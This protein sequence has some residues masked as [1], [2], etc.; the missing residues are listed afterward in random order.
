MRYF[1]STLVRLA[2]FDMSSPMFMYFYFNSTL[3]RLALLSG[4]RAIGRSVF[5]FYISTIS[6]NGAA[7]AVDAGL[8][9]QFYISTISTL[10]GDIDALAHDISI[11][12]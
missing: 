3:V 10:A 6:T 4:C 5:Q 12:H 9:F 8:L 2:L 11:L 7:R 1:N